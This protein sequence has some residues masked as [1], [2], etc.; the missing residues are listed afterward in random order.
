MK[1][2]ILLAF[3]I[4]TINQNFAQFNIIINEQSILEHD[5]VKY[6]DLKKVIISFKNPIKLL[7]GIDGVVIMNMKVYGDRAEQLGNFSVQKNKIDKTKEVLMN[8]TMSTYTE[9]YIGK[10]TGDKPHKIDSISI[11]TLLKNCVQNKA[12]VA[13][14][15]LSVYFRKYI[16]NGVHENFIRTS[17]AMPLLNDFIFYV[18]VID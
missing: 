3:F 5:R 10:I 11:T 8:D 6:D 12:K 4:F 2:F 13:K 18:D 14:V 9:P 15:V 16:K 1:Q 17:E 7:Y